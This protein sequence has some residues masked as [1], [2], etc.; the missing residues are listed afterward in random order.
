MILTGRGISALA[1]L[2]LLVA[3]A[4]AG[5][6][7]VRDRGKTAQQIFASD[8]AICHKSPQGLAKSGGLFGLRSFLREHYTASSETAALLTRYLE[9][10]GEAPAAREPR[11]EQRR[12]A[13]P[14]GDKPSDTKPSEVKPS[15]SP[16]PEPKAETKPEAKPD[17]K[18]EAKPET[19]PESTPAPKANS[20]INSG[21]AVTPASPASAN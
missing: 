5:A 8:C 11:R 7:D 12:N 9:A 21:I 1:G 15:E 3:A 19:K 16:K 20:E 18:P 13:K 2:V 6:Q 4:P 14:A 10:A 17:V